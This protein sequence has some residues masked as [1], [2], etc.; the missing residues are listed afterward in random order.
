[1]YKH[2]LVGH[3]L[4]VEADLAVRRAAQLARQHGARVTLVHLI[5]EYFPPAMLATVREAALMALRDSAASAGL[6]ARTVI[7]QERA[8]RGMV[9]T[10]EAQGADLLII[11]A[12]HQQLFE[13]F[14]GTTLERVV[15]QCP[16][17][18]LMA[19]SEQP[20][21]YRQAV[22]GLDFSV[23]ASNAW[24]GACEL[25]GKNTDLLAVQACEPGND[26]EET[27]LYLE[28]QRPLL[29]QLLH[30]ESRRVQGAL[31]HLKCLLSALPPQQALER[32][33]DE[34]PTSDLLV[35]GSRSRSAVHDLLL[36][37]TARHFL[38]RP[39]CDMLLSR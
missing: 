27:Q 35:L 39:P 17:P 13:R 5:E 11:G 31:P 9:A 3:D 21:A 4:S 1:M 30:D 36:G 34:Y 7:V 20:T 22:C 24:R 6:E 26:L 8:A 23:S 37:S 18:V 28:R 16:V 10:V 2:L 19:V 33:L 32:A 15:R 29:E 14:E 25:L 12:H 38:Q